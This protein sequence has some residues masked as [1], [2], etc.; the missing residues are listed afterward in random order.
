MGWSQAKLAARAG[1]SQSSV[2]RVEAGDPTVALR[3]VF[4]LV[5]AP[6]I[7]IDLELHPPHLEDRRRQV[8]P[9][10]ARA[11]AFV[12]RRLAAQGW[13]VR[14]EVEIGDGR[15]W[16]DLLAFR[17][18]DRS[19]FLAEIK[20][21]IHDA[22]AI[23]RTLSWYEREAWSAA[24]RLGWSPRRLASA[25]L[26]LAT[27]ANDRRV[28]ENSA[29]LRRTC[30]ARATALRTWLTEARSESLPRALAMVDPSSRRRAWLGSATADGRRTPAPY[31]HY[32]DFMRRMRAKR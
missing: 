11:C 14:L 22:G 28:L 26:L 30:P 8:D 29:L 21:E 18:A 25:L 20:T 13:D 5:D 24:R 15:G 27:D 19:V 10:H 1:T 23:H 17:S 7:R 3:T 16:I 32:A 12:A 2:S 4:D 31:A 6:G 9:A